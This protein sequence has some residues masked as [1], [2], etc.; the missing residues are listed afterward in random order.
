MKPNPQSSFLVTTTGEHRL[1]LRIA[2]GFFSRLRGL[3]LAAPLQIGEGML[4]SKC[5]SVHTC[6]MRQ[7]LD[8]LYLDEAGFVTKCVPH[9]SPWR[10]ST[11]NGKDAFGNRFRPALH[12]VELAAGTIAQWKIKV[13]SRVRLH[14]LNQANVFNLTKLNR[15]SEQCRG[16]GTSMRTAKKAAPSITFSTLTMH[17]EDRSQ[18]AQRPSITAP[19]SANNVT[20]LT[21]Q[22]RR[23]SQRGSVMTEFAIVAP[24]LTLIGLASIQYGLL[25]FAKNQYNHAAFMAARAGSTGN[26]NVEAIKDAYARALIP[27]YGGGTDAAKLAES[28]QKA[29]ADVDANTQIEMLNPTAESFLDFNNP[30]LQK[31]LGLS[32]QRVIPNGGLAYKKAAIVPGNSGQNIQDANLLK[33]RITQA[34]KPQVPVIG[35]MYTRYL[36]WLD[37]GVRA[38]DTQ[39]IK[40]GFIPVVTSVTLQMQSDAIE[41]KPISSPGRGNGGV[42]VDPGMPPVASTQPPSCSS[43]LCTTSGGQGASLGQGGS[44]GGGGSNQGTS[45]S[46]LMGEITNSGPP[47][48]VCVAPKSMMA[49]ITP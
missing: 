33:L 29:R 37:N 49:A 3:M 25:Y 1:N 12:V 31:A 14:A 9:L 27:L 7:Q 24:I 35:A 10:A 47:P 4:L 44:P 23:S 8:L 45:D 20:K 17:T 26:A 28:L 36:Q 6:F 48:G 21:S 5:R 40:L 2:N 46:N 16:T 18:S 11:S 43:A 15:R 42:A 41:G 30:E 34:Y 13:G 39:K 19:D 38:F 32:G 22:R